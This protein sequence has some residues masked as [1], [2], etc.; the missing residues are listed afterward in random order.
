MVGFFRAHTV[1]AVVVL[2]AVPYYKSV[3]RTRLPRVKRVR[4]RL[5]SARGEIVCQTVSHVECQVARRW[6]AEMCLLAQ[7]VTDVGKTI[8]D[9]CTILLSQTEQQGG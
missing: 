1:E 4:S 8:P 6:V 5:F 9:V 2:G 3:Q 7:Q